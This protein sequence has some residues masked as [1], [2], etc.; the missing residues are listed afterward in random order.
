MKK[1]V[2]IIALTCL[3]AGLFT[4]C[5]VVTDDP[6]D[7]PIETQ[8]PDVVTG[9][10][11]AKD[12]AALLKAAGKDG[13]WIILFNKDLTTDKEIVVEG[14]FTEADEN[15]ATK[16]VP[17]GRKIA[18]YAQDASRNKTASYTL[19]APKITVISKDTK[20]Q[21]GTFVGDVF[22]KQMDSNLLT[23]KLTEISIFQM[24][25]TRNHM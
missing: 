17:L 8:K 16:Q 4:G 3:F 10:S 15:D 2:L 19:T 1:L 7:D 18:L 24:K 9:A 13:E 11:V 12:E 5:N 6:T 23:Q 22:Y 25:N 21:G 14:E 20:I